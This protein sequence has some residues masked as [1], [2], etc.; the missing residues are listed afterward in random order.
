MKILI[1][2]TFFMIFALVFNLQTVYGEEF[3]G[4][5]AN[6][7]IFVGFDE[8]SSKIVYKMS[9]MEPLTW[10]DSIVDGRP[11][12][13]FTLIN[14]PDIVVAGFPQGNDEYLLTVQTYWGFEKFTIK[15]SD[16]LNV[17]SYETAEANPSDTLLEEYWKNKNN[18]VVRDADKEKE[19][20]VV[21][22]SEKEIVIVAKMA[23]QVPWMS[24]YVVDLKVYDPEINSKLDYYWKDGRIQ[25]VE[26][27]GKILDPNGGILGS[28]EGITSQYG[29]FTEHVYIPAN[30]NTNKPF[31]IDI[32]ASKY[33]DDSLATFSYLHQFSVYAPS[34]GGGSNPSCSG[35]DL[36]AP[37]GTCVPECP[38]GTT[39]DTTDW[40]CR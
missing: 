25:E 30:S 36:M 16:F 13:G 33:F 20:I 4:N 2:I 17:E 32:I 38:T 6:T 35:T 27:T 1:V 31:T 39:L 34:M 19:V 15:S 18:T 8:N 5:N 7:G 40:M 10:Y 3:Y 29:H 12:G 14:L 37:N 22:T 11:S 28:F 21:E 9:G 24:N 26:I 23:R